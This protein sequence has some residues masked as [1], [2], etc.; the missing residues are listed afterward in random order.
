M[1]NYPLIIKYSNNGIQA[2]NYIILINNLRIPQF[3]SQ[4]DTFY[5]RRFH[6]HRRHRPGLCRLSGPHP[7]LHQRDGTFQGGRWRWGEKICK[8]HGLTSNTWEVSWDLSYICL[9]MEMFFWINKLQTGRWNGCWSYKSGDVL[10]VFKIQKCGFYNDFTS[11]KMVVSW[12][13]SKQKNEDIILV[14][15]RLE[16]DWIWTRFWLGS[17]WMDWIGLDR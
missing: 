1:N 11:T 13:Y 4:S 5:L 8:N 9:N 3:E 15:D 10:W 16:L 2:I 14:S 6:L 12:G 7:G 17:E